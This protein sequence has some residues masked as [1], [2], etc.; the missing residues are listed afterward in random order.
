MGLVLR[1]L[2]GA[3]GPWILGCMLVA[4]VAGAGVLYVNGYD[5]GRN[6]ERARQSN[7]MASVIK[8]EKI[9]HEGELRQRGWQDVTEAQL[10]RDIRSDLR[11]RLE[12]LINTPPK[13]LIQKKV[14]T[15]ETGCSFPDPSLGDEFW[16]RYRSAGG[17]SGA[18]D[19][20]AASAVS[21]GMR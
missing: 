13:T 4:T 7:A 11:D 5:N 21:D 20:A 2:S 18:D 14:V 12:V 17:R 1:L 19:P 9:R 8:Q 3:A 15:H 6:A 16:V 10:Q